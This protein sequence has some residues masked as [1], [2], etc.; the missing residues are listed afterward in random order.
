MYVCIIKEALQINGNV[1]EYEECN[2]NDGIPLTL[3]MRAGFNKA[4]PFIFQDT[5]HISYNDLREKMLVNV[6]GILHTLTASMRYM[7]PS[8]ILSFELSVSGPC[9]HLLTPGDLGFISSNAP[10]LITFSNSDTN[11]VFPNSI[12]SEI[13]SMVEKTHYTRRQA[14]DSVEETGL[15]ITHELPCRM[16]TQWVSN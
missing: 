3:T 11:S 8:S 14:N 16:H 13:T 15:N 2:I 7:T 1:L 10:W 9:Q 4:A 12:M 6:T 5:F